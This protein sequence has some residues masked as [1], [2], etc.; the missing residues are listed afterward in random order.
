MI[1]LF[2][3]CADNYK[4]LSNV[5]T[6]SGEL[7]N[8]CTSSRRAMVV[9]ECGVTFPCRC[10]RLSIDD[11]NYCVLRSADGTGLATCVRKAMP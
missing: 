7:C 10:L 11:L 6:R 8:A 4:V 5:C 2:W 1:E 9:W 3:V